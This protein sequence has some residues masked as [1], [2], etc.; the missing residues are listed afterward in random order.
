VDGLERL[1][2][3]MN[4]VALPSYRE[5]MPTVLME[6]AAAGVPAVATDVPGCREAIVDGVT[7]LLVQAGDQDALADAI[8]KLAASAE[9]RKELGENARTHAA[10]F[11]RAKVV[12]DTITIY[13]NLVSRDWQRG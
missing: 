11:D 6:A 9:L 1:F 13:R 2:A 5:G 4:I 7:G 8:G 12:E 3:V 10:Q